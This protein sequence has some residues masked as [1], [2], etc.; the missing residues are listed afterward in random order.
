[1]HVPRHA[2]ARRAVERSPN[3]W[4]LRPAGEVSWSS[5]PVVIDQATD[6]GDSLIGA[7]H[8]L[9]FEE[10]WRPASPSSTSWSS[11]ISS[12][13]VRADRADPPDQLP[14]ELAR[15]GRGPDHDVGS[16]PR[17][18]RQLVRRGEPSTRGSL[19][20]GFVMTISQNF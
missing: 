10:G 6:P 11:E 7:E 14:P 13:Q 3:R 15:S 2:A 12:N 20:G 8:L 1:V 19:D 18:L 9:C 5:A 16:K 4:L 17:G